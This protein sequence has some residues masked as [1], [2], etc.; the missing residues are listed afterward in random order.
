VAAARR[1]GLEPP[2]AAT[3]RFP[4]FPESDEASWQELVLDH[5]GVRERAVV[6]LH[7]ELDALGPVATAVLRGLGPHWPGNAY[8]H[9]PILELARGGSV[10]TGAGGD[11]L[12]GTRASRHVLVARRRTRPRWRDV[13]ATALGLAPRPIRRFVWRH[14]NPGAGWLTEAGRALVGRALAQDEVGYPHRWDSSVRHWFGG[15]GY[16]GLRQTLPAVAGRYDV[17]LRSPFLEPAVVA[18]LALAGGP[19]GFVTRDAAMH[20]LFGDLLPGA[21]LTRPTKAGFSGALW[22]PATR[23]FTTG[24]NGG[25]VDR[26]YVDVDALRHEWAQPAP[27]FATILLLQAAWLHGERR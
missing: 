8:L 15:R 10:L 4:R 18:E 5:L 17:E 11:E 19:T 13:P 26:A 14:R 21:L 1:H 3:M 9:A 22:G 20:E 6:E 23:A 27:N 7:D 2:V 16:A 12:L 24:W 25:G